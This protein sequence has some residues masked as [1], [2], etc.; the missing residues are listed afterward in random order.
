MIIYVRTVDLEGKITREDMD[1]DTVEKM[2]EY[3]TEQ[4]KKVLPTTEDHIIP[5]LKEF[6]WKFLHP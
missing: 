3:V 5:T 2:V 1:F 6:E 4:S